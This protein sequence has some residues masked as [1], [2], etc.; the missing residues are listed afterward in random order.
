MNIQLFVITFNRRSASNDAKIKL[1]NKIAYFGKVSGSVPRNVSQ[2]VDGT[3]CPG[4]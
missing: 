2:G 4:G 1:R 3:A